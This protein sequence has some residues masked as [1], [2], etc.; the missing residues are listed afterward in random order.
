MF[1]GASTEVEKV[2]WGKLETGQR[3]RTLVSVG[4]GWAG[5]VGSSG[6]RS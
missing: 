3:A 2:G 6:L 1:E 5:K 4:G